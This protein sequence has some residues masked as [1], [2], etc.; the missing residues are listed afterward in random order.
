MTYYMTY[1]AYSY[2][3][4]HILH[5]TYSA[6]SLPLVFQFFAS[7]MLIAWS[8]MTGP[9]CSHTTTNIRHG[10]PVSYHNLRPECQPIP[11]ASGRGSFQY[12]P[13]GQEEA[14]P[15][16]RT[17]E[18]HTRLGLIHGARRRWLT[19]SQWQASTHPVNNKIIICI[20]CRIYRI[21]KI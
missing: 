7:A 10:R 17:L 16:W 15:V 8:P 6:Y 11:L 4:L 5:I 1:S 14:A 21:C 12:R 9:N 13:L 20:I 3:L 18:Q 19:G 2:S